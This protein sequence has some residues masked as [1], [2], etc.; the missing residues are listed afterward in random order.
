MIWVKL[1]SNEPTVTKDSTTN[2]PYV[3]ILI[4]SFFLHMFF[5]TFIIP[6]I[7]YIICVN[8]F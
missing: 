2:V 6:T 1:Q 7:N 8:S 4:F 5:K 3:D